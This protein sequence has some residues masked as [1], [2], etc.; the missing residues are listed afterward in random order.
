MRHRWPV[1]I[2]EIEKITEEYARH[3]IRQGF[4]LKEKI[5]SGLSGGVYLAYQKSLNRRVAIKFFDSAYAKNDQI[6]LKRFLREPRILAKL[7]H[8][9]IPYV[10]TTGEVPTSGGSVPYTILQYIAGETFE[11][12]IRNRNAISADIRVGYIRQILGALSL[13]HAESVI[14]RDIKPTNLMVLGSGHCFLIDFSIGVSLDAE[15]GL[16][17]ATKTGTHLG[18]VNYMSPEQKINMASVDGRS[19]IYSLGIV[20][21]EMLTG[22]T[23]ISNIAANL[24]EYPHSLR[25]AV[26]TACKHDVKDRFQTADDFLRDLGPPV[27]SV[28]G[29]HI[30]SG[31]SVCTNTK[32]PDA[33]WSSRGYYKG[34]KIIEE[35]VDSFCTSCGSKLYYQ[36]PG[37][38][39]PISNEPHCGH[40]GEKHFTI[41]ICETCGSYL[42]VVDMEADTKSLGCGKCRRRNATKTA[43]VSNSFD[44]E[45][46]F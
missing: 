20:L 3:L 2:M 31:L 4:E 36:C 21:L 44:D 46:P 23:D 39:A 28:S 7:Q 8:P 38:G 29:L 12:V 6:L 45:I 14:H 24:K 37:C 13:V 43:P 25:E 1:I 26:V 32:C 19:D 41:P 33:Q 30:R 5:N 10:V 35:S 42:E 27:F 18:S 34:P 40:C 22:S 15:P 11:S 17:R 16:T 9:G